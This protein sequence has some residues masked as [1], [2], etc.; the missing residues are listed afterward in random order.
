VTN[1]NP[2]VGM[3]LGQL[4]LNK[5]QIAVI[6][7]ALDDLVRERAT[8]SGT[9]VLISPISIGIGTRPDP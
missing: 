3:M 7:Q 6:Q 2:I 8:G 5:E 1:S 4:N 9:A